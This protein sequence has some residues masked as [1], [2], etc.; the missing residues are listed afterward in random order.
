[1][2]V[3]QLHSTSSLPTVSILFCAT[4][5]TLSELDDDPHTETYDLYAMLDR[6]A[7][8]LYRKSGS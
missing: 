6:K 4:H 2:F 8:Q 7:N 5:C 3:S 1:M